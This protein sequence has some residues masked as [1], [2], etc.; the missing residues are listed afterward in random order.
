MYIYKYIYI[1][2]H[3]WQYSKVSWKGTSRK[4]ITSQFRRVATSIFAIQSQDF[5]NLRFICL[6]CVVEGTQRSGPNGLR[7]R[8]WIDFAEFEARCK[9]LKPIGFDYSKVPATKAYTPCQSPAARIDT[10]VRSCHTT[11]LDE[12]SRS[13]KA[14]LFHIQNAKAPNNKIHIGTGCTCFEQQMVVLKVV[15]VTVPILT[16]GSDSTIE[17]LLAVRMIP[18]E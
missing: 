3:I 7:V 10:E 16:T 12:Q 11:Q 15:L 6:N 8:W 1:Y 5:Y 4:C 9:D 14:K 13:S 18:K 2:I 17:S